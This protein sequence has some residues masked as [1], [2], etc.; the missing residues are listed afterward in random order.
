MKPLLQTRK[1]NLIGAFVFLLIGVVTFAQMAAIGEH[2]D[3]SDPGAAGYPNLIGGA[4]IVL[5]VL[6]AFQRDKKEATP[7]R[8]ELLNVLAAIAATFAYIYAMHPLGYVLATALFLVVT[9]LLMGIRSI[10]ALLVVPVGLA[11]LNFYLFYV[12]FGVPLPYSFIE[13][14]LT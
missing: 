10:I 6:L 12:A 13:R 3:G 1:A 9:M 4:M 7:T 8:G 2:P 5:A 14:L 11:V